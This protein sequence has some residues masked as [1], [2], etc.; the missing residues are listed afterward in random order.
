MHSSENICYPIQ[1][2]HSEQLT[3]MKALYL[4]LEQDLNYHKLLLN[5]KENFP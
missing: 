5:E 3:K 1:Y 2:F 4:T